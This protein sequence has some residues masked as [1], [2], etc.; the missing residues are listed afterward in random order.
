MVY[1][2]VQTHFIRK[3]VFDVFEERLEDIHKVGKNKTHL[4]SYKLSG[5]ILDVHLYIY[6]LIHSHPFIY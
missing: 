5:N 3:V 6:P 2:S 1:I 4:Q